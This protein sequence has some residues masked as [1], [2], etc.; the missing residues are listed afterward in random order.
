MSWSKFSLIILLNGF[1]YH[2]GSSIHNNRLTQ[3][4]V[5][6]FVGCNL[7]MSTA[8]KPVFQ[9]FVKG[10]NARVSLPCTKTLRTSVIPKVVNI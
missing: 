9:S 3:K 4:L 10:L 1:Y 5:D 8:D 2:I 6:F 7:P